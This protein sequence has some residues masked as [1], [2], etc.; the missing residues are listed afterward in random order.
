LLGGDQTGAPLA[1]AIL[2]DWFAPNITTDPRKGIGNWPLDEVVH[3]LKT[4]TNSW[5]LASGPMAEAVVHSTSLMTNEDLAAIAAYLK[6]SGVA[7]STSHP[8]SVSA[9][10][11][12][13]RAGAAIYKDNCA[14][15][16][17]DSGVGE[18]A[19]FPSLS[20]SALVQS[21]DVTTLAR[22]ILQGSRAVATPDKLTAPAMPAFDWRLN[23]AQIAAVLTFIR[24]RWGNAAA[25][26]AASTVARQRALLARSP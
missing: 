21:D 8:T 14:A 25:P 22:L 16:H 3:Y 9:N 19:L 17:K 23:D 6:D 1:G 12:A 7:V 5:T 11:P 4:G 20:G 18:S 10:D 13:M 15:C 2:Q 26:V 24:N